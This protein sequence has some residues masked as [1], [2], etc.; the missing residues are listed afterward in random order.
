MPVVDAHCHVWERWPFP[1]VPHPEVWGD[2]A[3]LL[4]EMDAAGVGVAHVVAAHNALNP[5]N[6]EHVAAVAASWPE[7]FRLVADVSDGAFAHGVATDWGAGDP[8]AWLESR[9][10]VGF[11]VK[12]LADGAGAWLLTREGDAVLELA[13]ARGLYASVALFP[14]LQAR[15]REVAR[16]HPGV[17]FLVPHLGRA[18]AKQPIPFDGFQEVLETAALPNVAIKLSGLHHVSQRAWEFPYADCAWMVRAIYE[19]YGAER[20]CWGSDFPALR[21]ATT[22]VQRLELVRSGCDFLGA[23]EREL[24][25]GG[26]LERITRRAG[27]L[28]A[29]PAGVGAAG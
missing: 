15:L 24:V 3:L 23:A 27:A 26:S 7:R 29:A 18:R 11:S 12:L 9:E 2:A 17:W 13:A 16:R 21:S 4:H 28:S 8:P 19:R 6:T 20:L 1:P 14:P 10:L 25:L 5:S 22:Y